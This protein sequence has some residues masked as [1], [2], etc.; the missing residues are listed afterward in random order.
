[1]KSGVNP[2]NFKGLVMLVL[3]TIAFSLSG[4]SLPQIETRFANPTYNR[5]TRNFYLDVELHSK[6]STEILF[7][8]NLRFF[9]DASKLSF[10]NVDQFHQGYGILGSAPQVNVGNEQGG[11]QLFGFTDAATF[12]N[13]AV[14]LLDERFPM[15]IKP[16]T[17]VKAF[18]LCFKVPAITLEKDNFCPSVIWDLKAIEGQGGFS[19]SAGLVITVA[20]TNRSSRYESAP[21]KASVV[22]FNWTSDSD[23]SLPYGSTVAAECISIGETTA[24]ESPDKTDAKG[25]ALFQNQPNPFDVQTTIDF[26]LP[27]AQHVSIIL[28]DVDGVIKEEI[29]GYYERGRNQVELK[30][31]PWMAETGLIYYQLKTE[32]YTSKTFSMSLVRA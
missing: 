32:K 2:N 1:M 30:Q 13:G 5:E 7:G 22:H 4:Q 11:I 27:S 21:A 6:T 19:G 18:R 29:K 12:I 17:W 9:Y 23:A 14:Q 25:F 8:M 15:Q 31:K 3:C 26:I 10:Q 20:E 24:T 16:E 28:F